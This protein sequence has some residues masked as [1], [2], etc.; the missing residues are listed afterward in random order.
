MGRLKKYVF[1]EEAME[2][3]IA[4]YEIPA[5]VGLRYCEE[6]EWYLQ[7]REGEVVIPIIAFLEGG[8]RIPM[9]PVMRGYLTYFR[10]TPTQCASTMFRILGS[11]DALNEK[12]GL[13]L[14]HHDVN[15]CYNFQH[16]KNNSYYM[17]TLDDRVRLIQC[18]P[19]SN[20]GM[21]ED[22]LI[23]FGAWHDGIHCP[24]TEG[25]PGGAVGIGGDSEILTCFLCHFFL[26]C[27]VTNRG[28]ASFL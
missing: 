24:T 18:L 10:L 17:R 15:Y 7:R 6:G 16:L 25:T 4:D 8:M 28:C 22:F 13:R 3:F 9:G 5:D 21:N 14:T 1:T 2:K 20:K 27:L 12:M 26:Y 23:V 11:V 19:E